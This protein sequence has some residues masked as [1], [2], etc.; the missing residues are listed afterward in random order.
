MMLAAG[1]LLFGGGVI[2][3]FAYSWNVLPRLAR[4]AIV[5]LL[6]AGIFAGRAACFG[7]AL[8]TGS[9]LALIGQTTKRRGPVAAVRLLAVLIL[10]GAFATRQPDLWLLSCLLANVALGLRPWPSDIPTWISF[11][12]DLAV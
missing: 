7:A 11:G 8:L 9:L 6:L 4:F 12:F 1:T 2:F 10:P 5:E 3:F